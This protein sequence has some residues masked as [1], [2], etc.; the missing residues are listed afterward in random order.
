MH[1]DQPWS[2]GGWG[3][4]G[5]HNGAVELRGANR[6]PQQ[7]A[8]CLSESDD[9]G[10]DLLGYASGEGRGSLVRV[11]DARRLTRVPSDLATFDL[12]AGT[13]FWAVGNPSPSISKCLDGGFVSY[14]FVDSLILGI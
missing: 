7:A 13:M 1:T 4:R 11:R 9:G 2:R 8:T 14:M 5:R 6:S 10:A 3:T 12:R